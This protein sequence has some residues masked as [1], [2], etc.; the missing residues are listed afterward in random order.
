MR[1]NLERENNNKN[2][3]NESINFKLIFDYLYS[4]KRLFIIIFLFC[5]S[6]FFLVSR[7]QKSRNIKYAGSFQI[8]IEDPIKSKDLSSNSKGG[9]SSLLPGYTTS[10]DIFTL[11]S[12]LR[13]DLVLGNLSN[14]YKLKTSDIKNMIS[15]T[16]G[17]PSN[18]ADGV[19]VIKLELEDKLLGNKLISD[20]AQTYVDAARLYREK[21][22]QEGIEFINKTKPNFEEELEKL[23]KRYRYLEEK[24]VLIQ[25]GRGVSGM[26]FG[27]SNLVSKVDQIKSKLNFTI[28]EN[29]EL[30]RYLEKN[31]I[32]INNE[33]AKELITK[34]SLV[35]QINPSNIDN[36]LTNEKLISNI[37][38]RINK[39][40]KTINYLKNQIQEIKFEFNNP[41]LLTRS[42]SKL[43]E[44]IVLV[45]EALKNLSTSSELFKIQI[46]Q[47][48]T[49]WN[50]IEKPY[51][52]TEPVSK[53]FLNEFLM[54]SSISAFFS[55]LLIIT[56]ILIED[57][58][59]NNNQITE[60][61]GLKIIGSLPK[62]DKDLYQKLK[63]NQFID[64]DFKTMD[65]SNKKL[66]DF[67]NYFLSFCS[68][69]KELKNKEKSSIFLISSPFNN[70]DTFIDFYTSK[71]FSSIGEK[72]L[73]IDTN[74][75]E[76]KMNEII[77]N[78]N[79]VG[80]FDYLSN[81]QINFEEILSHSKINPNL[82]IAY[83]GD[84]GKNNSLLILSKRMEEL[85]K[86]L[87]QK[88]S[89]I[90]IKSQNLHNAE[91]VSMSK[92]ADLTIIE[93]DK[94]KITK[95]NF[96]NLLVKLKDHLDSIN[97]LIN[98]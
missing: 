72:T 82:D 1:D 70:Y 31:S 32:D 94:N 98:E 15:I 79:P 49:P 51:M 60:F 73:L 39:N 44:E 84:T 21:K 46:A 53:P 19:L 7:I 57:K 77:E 37:K 52:G 50:I 96:K 59:A 76:Y 47:N 12:F 48:S 78:K 68:S 63:D 29:S 56:I 85:L 86:N 42:I 26:E 17:G 27:I 95:T 41:E 3:E 55:L 87:K 75:D 14:K 33:K 18:N 22:L 43:L 13:S 91:T 88:Y 25:G 67:E 16:R 38:E 62:I 6:G 35:D 45:K 58:F 64:K 81:N 30:L 90:F 10:S 83:Q 66:L 92:L 69:L 89:Y 8:L 11:S 40:I 28:E 71:F 20:L 9:Q 36:F 80:L 23:D 2:K 74:F 97:L 65:K 4:K 61:S 93:F 54:I 34:Y 24:Y 5:F